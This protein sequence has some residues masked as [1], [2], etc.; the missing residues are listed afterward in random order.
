[1]LEI[2]SLKVPNCDRRLIKFYN[3]MLKQ[4][5]NDKCFLFCKALSYLNIEVYKQ[6]LRVLNKVIKRDK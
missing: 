1:M 2:C 5:P 4:I 6:A 3:E